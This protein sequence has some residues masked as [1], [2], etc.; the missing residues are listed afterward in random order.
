MK[1]QSLGFNINLCLGLALAFWLSAC[2]APGTAE[3]KPHQKPGK[4]QALLALHLE[5][6]ADGTPH[7]SNITVPRGA[8]TPL[9]VEATP[10]LDSGS[11]LEAAVVETDKFGGFAMKLQFNQHGIFALDTIT[12]ANRGRH[13]AILC[14]YGDKRW[15]AA[16]LITRRV[17]DGLLQF[18][19]D[20]SREEADY[21]VR[22]LNNV[23]AKLKKKGAL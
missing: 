1:F 11:L 4:E 7:S 9:S 10:F 6:H 15:L 21:I 3:P 23:A 14:Q 12:S 20:V 19:A 16:P 18:A 17:S 5:T 2:K 8:T 22:G 13:L